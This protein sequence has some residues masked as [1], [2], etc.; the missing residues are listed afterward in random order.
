MDFYRQIISIQGKRII[1]I[2]KRLP[3]K[4]VISL[5]NIYFKQ[6]MFRGTFI[7]REFEFNIVDRIM[8]RGDRVIDIE[9]NVGH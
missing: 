9:E 7:C 4:Y 5:K 1:K 6:Q 2:L 8:G 3:N